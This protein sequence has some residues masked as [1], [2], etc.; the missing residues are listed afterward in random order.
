[1][2]SGRKETSGQIIYV[3]RSGVGAELV[4]ERDN[5]P[6]EPEYKQL[7]ALWVQSQAS[8]SGRSSG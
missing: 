3:K 6:K 2:R 5:N 8:P 4:L 7:I 1:M